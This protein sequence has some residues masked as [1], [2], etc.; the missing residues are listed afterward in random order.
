[1]WLKQSIDILENVVMLGTVHNY[2]VQQ[3]VDACERQQAE[4][5]KQLAELK[6]TISKEGA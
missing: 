5:E 2:S 1:M 4:L 3:V 6:A